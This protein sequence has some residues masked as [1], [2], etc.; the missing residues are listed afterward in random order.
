MSFYDPSNSGKILV[1]NLKMLFLTPD[2]F[3][4]LAAKSKKLNSGP[5]KGGRPICR[6]VLSPAMSDVLMK[7]MDASGE[8]EQSQAPTVKLDYHSLV[9]LV[10]KAKERLKTQ[11]S[12]V[13]IQL[14]IL[15][16]LDGTTEDEERPVH[17]QQPVS[18]GM[19]FLALP[20]GN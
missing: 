4:K 17:V 18:K 13:I 19:Q 14:S 8:F 5:K 20:I 6:F 3:C 1:K 16:S 11:V 15:D 7:F 2:A 10:T 12:N 9:Q